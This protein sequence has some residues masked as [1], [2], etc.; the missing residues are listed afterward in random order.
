VIGVGQVHDE[1]GERATVARAGD[2]AAVGGDNPL[3]ERET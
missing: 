2:S 3:R 1:L